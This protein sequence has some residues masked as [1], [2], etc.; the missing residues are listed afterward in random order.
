MPPPHTSTGAKIEGYLNIFLNYQVH[1][2]DA[3]WIF[4]LKLA[5]SFIDI[6]GGDGM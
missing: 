1:T 3:A 2:C 4:F 6:S 5:Y